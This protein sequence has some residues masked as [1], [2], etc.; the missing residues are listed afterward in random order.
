[1]T[2]WFLLA[3]SPLISLSQYILNGAATQNTCNCYTLT[4]A[5]FTQAGSV[6]N[7]TKINLNN[8]FDF[9]FNVYLGCQD[10][11]GADGI[12]FILQP[13]STSLG[14]TGEG[15]GFIGITPSVG[16]SLDT[17]QNFNLNDPAY[18]HI[19]IQINGNATHGSDL[20]GPVQASTTSENIE[21]C[22]WHVFR[23]TW[24]PATQS[25]KAYFDDHLRVETQINL[26]GTIFNN[27][28][29]VYWGFTA[30]TG[31]ANNLQQF[32][33]ALNPRFSTNAPNNS[34]CAGEP[35]TFIESSVAFAPIQSWFWDFGDGATSSLRN[36][37]P[38]TYSTAGVYNVKLV[39]TGLD[40][41]VSDPLQKTITIG[42]KPLAHFQVFDTCVGKPA[43]IVDQ[44]TNA[45]G[46][47]NAWTWVVDGVVTTGDPSSLLAVSTPGMH[48][49][50]LVVKT[51]IGCESDTATKTFIAS[52]APVIDMT[53][54]DGCTN[55]PINFFGE[56]LDN[57][58]TITEW[59]WSF[60]DGTTS[61]LEDPVHAY[62][63]PGQKNVRLSA[64]AGNGCSAE[65]TK[66]VSI[67]AVTVRTIRDT[68]V[69]P[70]IPF[71][72]TST[73][74]ATSS[75]TPS[76]LWTPSTG[77]SDPFI[78]SPDVTI[79]DDATYVITATTPEGC[80]S[81]DTVNLKAFK[82]SSV[83]V[84]TGF[85]P[86]G[87]GKND[88]LRGLYVGIKKVDYFRVYNRWGQL[89]FSTNSLT[90]GWDGAI[91]GVKQATGTYIWMLRAEDLAGKVY[92][93]KGI[94]T[95]IR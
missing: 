92:E 61:K 62:T 8:L 66:T 82:G 3:F 39:I 22:E 51:N 6:W 30:A 53:V 34:V 9:S 78:Q 18:D 89:I 10:V 67:G 65:V 83:Y 55:T 59:N 42:S 37:P 14:S 95:L 77:L 15:L 79:Q 91:N 86:N 45:V 40:G 12:V 94:C 5:S 73:W 1:M 25:L 68:L 49:V 54:L 75:G 27:D 33:T 38:H 11:N 19:S 29:N 47:I 80:K 64:A 28:P 32:C 36:P 52:Y 21:D 26:I 16:I 69:L 56:Q 58:T 63:M 46:L 90:R 74:T 44:S 57:Q 20:A 43:R 31:G 35:I 24:N 87:D 93:M 13:N 85:T 60:G 41:C 48:T 84:P 71:Q 23:I 88:F 81:K 2:F 72:L 70:N 4:P 50:K 76:F 7:G 17:W